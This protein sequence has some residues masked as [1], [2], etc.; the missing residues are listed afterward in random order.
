MIQKH[1]TDRNS[2]PF[3]WRWV[4][5]CL[6]YLFLVLVIA[7]HR[8][9]A[10]F[11]DDGL[12]LKM[13]WEAA[14]GYGWDTMLPQAPSYLFNALLMK[15]G[16]NELLQFRIVNYSLCFIGAILFFVGLNS[17][18]DRL[19][20]VPL[21]VT[22]SILVFLNSIECPNS[23]ALHFFLIGLGCYFL[24]LR[25]SSSWQTFLLGLSALALALCGFTH[26]AMVIA[27]F[28]IGAFICILDPI[29]RRSIFPYLLTGTLFCLW[30]WYIDEVGLAILLKVPTYHETS[31]VELLKRIY[32]IFKFLAVPLIYFVVIM[33]FTKRFGSKKTIVVQSLLIFS[34]IFL[35]L[36]S[37]INGILDLHWKFPG[38]IDFHQIPGAIYYSLF[39]IIFSSIAAAYYP[40]AKNEELFLVNGRNLIIQWIK[41]NG[42]QTQ[43]YKL[44]L[45]IAGFLLLP[46]GLAAGSN[47][48]ILVGLVYFSGPALGLA[49]MIWSKESSGIKDAYLY[50][51][52]AG[53]ILIFLIFTLYY[54][55]P[56]A[57]PPIDNGEV[58][59][60]QPHLLSIVETRQYQKSLEQLDL[61]YQ[62]N[63]CQDKLLLTL[64]NIP[65]IYYIFQHP[66]PPKIGI[67]RPLYYFPS[68]EILELL[69]A[70]NHWCV[71]DIT[72]TETKVGIDQNHGI[73]NRE[74]VRNFLKSQSAQS[75][76][77]VAPSKNFVSEINFYIR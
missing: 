28:I 76:V 22:A 23:L 73:D 77:I 34:P 69:R 35:A 38:S 44:F 1:E 55:H 70:S 21:A 54:N 67:V 24:A 53:W 65:T 51:F 32:L 45:A 17:G 5:P 25:A 14:Y 6:C 8:G 48:A 47:T 9:A 30:A 52:A 62:Q 58:V 41:N 37:L 26:A 13:S 56:S 39:F 43:N 19:N 16:V 36:V 50:S 33:W 60:S 15:F 31:L 20:L 61:I 71:I 4:I 40:F 57:N 49:L 66:S 10:W 42:P 68:N 64:D 29:T 12:F 74:A 18:K 59:L 2:L 72:G 3:F 7:P 11:S 75:H 63:Q 46:A 27:I